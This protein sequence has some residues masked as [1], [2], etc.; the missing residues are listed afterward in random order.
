MRGERGQTLPCLTA[1]WVEWTKRERE[2]ERGRR[3]L[4]AARANNFHY[5]LNTQ[6]N[7]EL[8][9]PIPTLP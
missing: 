1:P 8:E 5:V 7:C 6:V 2:R 3:A 9:E 4:T